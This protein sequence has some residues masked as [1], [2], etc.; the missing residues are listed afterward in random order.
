VKRNLS[1][2]C[3]DEEYATILEAMRRRPEKRLVHQGARSAIQAKATA[4][5]RIAA[6]CREYLDRPAAEP[7]KP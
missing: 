1:L 7:A 5:A 6:I 3:A 4:G 2:T